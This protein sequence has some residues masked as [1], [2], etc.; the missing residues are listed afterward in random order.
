MFITPDRRTLIA[1]SLALLTTAAVGCSPVKTQVSTSR[2]LD[3]QKLRAGLIAI[4]DHAR[5]AIL[6]LGL[7]VLGTGA[8]WFSDESGRYPLANLAKLVIAAAALARVESGRLTLNERLHITLEDLSPPPSRINLQVFRGHTETGLWLPA[9]DL[10]ALAIQHDDSTASD[11]LMRRI[12]GPAAVT[13]WLRAKDI[14][15]LRVDRYDR[16]RLCDLFDIGAFQP[17]WARPHE[18]EEAKE[19][20]APAVRE[21]AMDAYLADSRDTASAPG[22]VTFLEK[23]AS[24]ALISANSTAFLTQL[25]DEAEPHGGLMTGLPPGARVARKAGAT[26]SALGFTAADNELAI[27]TLADGMRLAIAIFLAGSTATEKARAKSFGDMG[28]LIA[29]ALNSA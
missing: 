2:V 8:R 6:N 23:L 26:P 18:W 17:S 22:A 5:P 19:Q 9:A 12:G 29:Q 10:I 24:G 21:G 27:V 28:R 14:E 4:A 7:G 20:R 3:A 1:T 15:G 16:E 11:V 13:T 25:M